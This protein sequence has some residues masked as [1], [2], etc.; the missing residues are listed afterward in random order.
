MDEVQQD[1]GYDPVF[2]ATEKS[3]G[4][5]VEQ[6]HQSDF[7]QSFEQFSQQ[8]Y[9]DPDGD[10]YEEERHITYDL[11]AGMKH[12]AHFRRYHIGEFKTGVEA[13]EERPQVCNL[14]DEAVQ[15]SP[16]QSDK[17]NDKQYSVQRVHGLKIKD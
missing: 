10:E 11:R 15:E 3:T 2:Q 12:G 9:A 13:K 4:Y 14:I 5:F 6:A 17:Q 1:T 8:H 16:D 7:H